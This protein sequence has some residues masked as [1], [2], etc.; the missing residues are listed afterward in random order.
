MTETPVAV[1]ASPAL[2]LRRV[3]AYRGIRVLAWD[4]DV[5]YG[6]RGYQIVRLHVG[7]QAGKGAEWE[8]VA[9]FRPVWWRNLTSRVALSYRLMRDGFHALALLGSPLEG[10]IGRASCRERG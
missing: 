4:G 3:A 8:V 10:E 9:R 7:E 2:K 1:A 5:L 6:C